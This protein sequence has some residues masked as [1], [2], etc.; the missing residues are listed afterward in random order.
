MP[1]GGIIHQPPGSGSCGQ[2]CVAMAAG[3]TI[4]EAVRVIGKDGDTGAGDLVRGLRALGVTCKR[5]PVYSRL[6]LDQY[7]ILGIVYLDNDRTGHWMLLWD[8][9]IYDPAVK[10][11]SPHPWRIEEI[12]RIL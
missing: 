5:L 6:R 9:T 1:P 12:V 4:E 3:V 10:V 11:Q 8:G 7:A 2:A